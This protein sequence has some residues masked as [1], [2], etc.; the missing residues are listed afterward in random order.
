MRQ[1]LTKLDLYKSPIDIK[2]KGSN[3]SSKCGG[4]ISI[5]IICFSILFVYQTFIDFF[6]FR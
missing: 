1:F 2:Y 5:V 6:S 4:I 3:T